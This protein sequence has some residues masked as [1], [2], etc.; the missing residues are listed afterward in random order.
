MFTL[1]VGARH[2]A[3]AVVKYAAEIGCSDAKSSYDELSKWYR[4]D[5]QCE[6]KHRRQ[7]IGFA[8]GLEA[9]EPS[10]PLVEF[11]PAE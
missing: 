9:L 4:I 5:V 6:L 8:D 7:L 11:E 10:E 3:R 1:F 2:H